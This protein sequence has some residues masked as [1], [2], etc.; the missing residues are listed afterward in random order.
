MRTPASFETSRVN[1]S[2][3]VRKATVF[4]QLK[5]GSEPIGSPPSVHLASSAASI[6]LNFFPVH[7]E[8]KRRTLP[9]DTDHVF[10]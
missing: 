3:I 9:G 6:G 7:G 4:E 8:K 5:A 1:F 10:L 2:F